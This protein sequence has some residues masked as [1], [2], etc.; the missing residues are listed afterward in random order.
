MKAYRFRLYPNK[1]TTDSLNHTFDLCR[2]TY[3]QLL[4]RLNNQ[5][6]V[7]RNAIQHHVVELKKQYPELQ[8][9]YSKTLQYE[10]YRLFSNLRSLAKLK[11]NGVRHGKLRFKGRDWFKTIQYN[12]SGYKITKTGKRLDRL[13][14]SKIGDIPI[15]VHRD[16]LGN[17]KQITIKKSIG[18][19][20]AIIITDEKYQMQHGN[21]E[22]GFDVGVMSFLTD[23]DGNKTGN[24][25]FYNKSLVQI[26]KAHQELSRKKRGSNNRLKAKHNLARL[27]EKSTIRKEI[28]SIRLQPKL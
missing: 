19:W 15:R 2:F 11:K 17:I 27:Y 25:L 18:K 5:E 22:L 12:Q 20:Y 26:Q 14:L 13:H 10:C 8:T 28:F 3:N 21:K 4:E 9:V 23:S 7:D 1:T 24:P 6:K 16:F